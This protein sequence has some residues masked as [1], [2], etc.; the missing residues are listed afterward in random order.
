MNRPDAALH[1]R[2]TAKPLLSRE[3]LYFFAKIL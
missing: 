2:N 1:L 3:A